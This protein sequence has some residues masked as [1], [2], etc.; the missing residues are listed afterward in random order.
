MIELYHTGGGCW[1][2]QVQEPDAPGL[3]ALITVPDGAAIP[4]TPEVDPMMIGIY[5]EEDSDDLGLT[6]LTGR[7][8]L[9]E[10]YEAHVGYSP[11]ADI[12]SLTPILELMDRVASHLLL[13]AHEERANS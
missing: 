12:G 13:R 4:E 1:A 7:I 11:D 10:W 2:Y 9:I 5:S 6:T 8:G 3:Y